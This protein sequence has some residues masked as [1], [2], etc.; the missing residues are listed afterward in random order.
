MKYAFA[1]F[2]KRK[3]IRYIKSTVNWY[4]CISIEDFEY[5]NIETHKH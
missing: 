1:N 4:D 5:T 2:F 3:N